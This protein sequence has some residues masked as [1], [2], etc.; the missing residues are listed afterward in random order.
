MLLEFDIRV[1][2]KK[3]VVVAVHFSWSKL[4]ARQDAL[5]VKLQVNV[6]VEARVIHRVTRM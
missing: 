5:V 4:G 6:D 2:V 3:F 1:G